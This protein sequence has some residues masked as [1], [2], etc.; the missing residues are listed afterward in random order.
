MQQA[1]NVASVVSAAAAAAA[2]AAAAAAAA[3]VAD[4]VAAAAKCNIYYASSIW[5]K[6]LLRIRTLRFL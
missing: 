4:R 2:V 5:K 6:R 1:V 3:R